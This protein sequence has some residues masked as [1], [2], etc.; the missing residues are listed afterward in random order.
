M[1]P[2]PTSGF[3]LSAALW[4][5]LFPGNIHAAPGD[6]YVGD[7][8]GTIFKF[9]PDGSK[10]TF[11]SGIKEV[12]GL[13]FDRSG[14]LF[15][16][17]GATGVIWMFTSNGTK[18]IFTSGLEHPV[19]LAFD[20]EGHLFVTDIC[21]GDIGCGTIFKFTSTGTKSTFSS[22]TNFLG[23][24]LDS[25]G[26][27]FASVGGAT[28][29]S[30]GIVRFTPEGQESI[31]GSQG[32]PGIVFDSSGN[33]Y[34]TTLSDVIFKYTPDGRYSIFAA[35]EGDSLGLAFDGGGNL[36]T[37]E[38]TSG[39]ISKFSPTGTKSIFASGL[40]RPMFLAFE[41]LV[42]KLRNISAR[43]LV[44]TGNDVLIG[45]F[46][47]G[48]NGVATNGVVIRAIGPSLGQVGV[49]NP[50]L[51]PILELYS[52]NGVLLYRNDNW[53]DSQASQIAITG[54]A[55]PDPRESA[56]LAM[57]PAGSFTAIVRGAGNTTG[58]ALV[59]IYNLP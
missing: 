52:S 33:L 29:L 18:T 12:N 48:G 8:L 19:A 5:L 15:V 32:G 51:D 45:G 16:A 43:G 56:I 9:A 46:I 13:A 58:T 30:G 21:G 28:Q 20:G 59:E 2:R 27:L 1:K 57:L 4:L 11:A 31:F 50:L 49:S 39:S 24:A 6:L 25:A 41:P 7:A 36:Y 47:L 53:Q 44:G 55:P 42:E 38:S 37:T 26:N 23:L 35:A 17:E 3:L 22:G 14:R 10:L 54:L 40:T 34:A